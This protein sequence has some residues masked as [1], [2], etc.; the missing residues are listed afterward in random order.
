MGVP[1]EVWV[2]AVK[3]HPLKFRFEGLP[4]EYHCGRR[5]WYTDVRE[6]AVADERFMDRWMER[7]R[8][9]TV[10]ELEHELEMPA[11]K[12]DEDQPMVE[13]YATFLRGKFWQN[14]D[15]PE[16]INLAPARKVIELLEPKEPIKRRFDPDIDADSLRFEWSCEEAQ[17][18]WAW[19]D[20]RN[21]S[22]DDLLKEHPPTHV[23]D[24]ASGEA[25]PVEDVVF[26]CPGCHNQPIRKEQLDG[27]HYY[28]GL[29]GGE[30]APSEG[31]TLESWA[32][33]MAVKLWPFKE[34]P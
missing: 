14:W 2:D 16:N 7:E 26:I 19:S 23:L 15:E 13:N 24:H 18:E 32:E 25:V 12:G 28:C 1:I 3:K 31:E 17:P 5:G 30:S 10:E 22:P 8:K 21:N 4:G 33:A 11:P 20:I 9:G 6:A 29:C 27:A 34:V